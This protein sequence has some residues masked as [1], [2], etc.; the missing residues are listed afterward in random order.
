MMPPSI[1]TDRRHS[2]TSSILGPLAPSI[3][4]DVTIS[5]DTA[6][7]GSETEYSITGS[8][9]NFPASEIDIDDQMITGGT[10]AIGGTAIPGGTISNALGVVLGVSYSPGAEFSHEQ[11]GGGPP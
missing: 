11:P 1:C 5:L 4:W 7:D 6:S 3:H 8:R 9:G 10:V 2:R